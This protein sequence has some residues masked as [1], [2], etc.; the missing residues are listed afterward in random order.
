[1]KNTFKLW[2]EIFSSP[3]KGFSELNG[4]TTIAL[5]L[6]IVLILVLAGSAIL[7]P[8]LSSDAYT[9]AISRVQI[10][11]LKER[12]T[13]IT[14]EQ[15]DMMEQQLQSGSVKTIT[16]LS[17][18]AGAVI[19]YIAITVISVLI[20]KL[21]LLIFKEKA[22]FKLLFRIIIFIAVISALQMIIKNLITAVTDFERVLS[23]VQTTSDLQYALSSPVSLAVIFSPGKLNTSVYYLIDSFTDIFN[24]LYYGFLY[25]GLKYACGINGKKA[26]GATIVFAVLMVAVGF[27]FTLLT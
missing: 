6:I 26:L 12:G 14:D 13:E 22:A 5:P 25:T 16:L 8:V 21:I 24:W 7:I 3:S 23:H 17:S 20:L 2:T 18:T 27:V 1:M 11:T 15:I 19:G 4:S 10:N 9:S